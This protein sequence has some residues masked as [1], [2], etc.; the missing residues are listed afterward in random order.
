[1]VYTIGEVAKI[2]DV[3]IHTLRYYEDEK[4]ISVERDEKGNRLYSETDI[5]WLYMIRCFR[6]IEMPISNLKEYAS[7]FLQD[8]VNIVQCKEILL[9]YKEI[10][11]K[12]HEAIKKSLVLID[13][14]LNYYEEVDKTDTPKKIK[15][16]DYFA[17]WETYK[18]KQGDRENE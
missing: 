10:V 3:S 8:E 7:L 9:K 14:K 11:K 18:R 16:R 15:C 12:K 2:L 4:L 1:M 5:D 6:D 13:R 17:D